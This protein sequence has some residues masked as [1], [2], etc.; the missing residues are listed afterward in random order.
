MLYNIFM[1]QRFEEPAIPQMNMEADE[2]DVGELYVA[3]SRSTYPE[4]VLLFEKHFCLIPF[5]FPSF[6]ISISW[7]LVPEQLVSLLDILNVERRELHSLYRRSVVYGGK[8]Y[9]FSILPIY[10]PERKFLNEYLL[11]RFLAIKKNILSSTDEE[12]SMSSS[13]IVY[14]EERIATISHSLDWIPRELN[15]SPL[16][17]QTKFLQIFYNGMMAA[18]GGNTTNLKIRRKFVEIYLYAQGLLIGDYFNYLTS[19]Y[20]SRVS[21]Y[22]LNPLP[23]KLKLVLLHELGILDHLKN[24]FAA[25]KNTSGPSS[26]ASVISLLTSEHT[27]NYNEVFRHLSVLGTGHPKDSLTNTN[28]KFVAQKLSGISPDRQLL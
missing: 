21:T 10:I 11:D 13:P 22:S 26:L 6:D 15:K 1:G 19:I 12:L 8:S 27:I 28:K 7:Y 18:Q 9:E 5:T 4:K 14:L 23:L 2:L 16:S 3:F 20:A 25:D 17:V 24:R